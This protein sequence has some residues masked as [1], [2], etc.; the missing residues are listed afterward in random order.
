MPIAR[1]RIN[2]LTQKEY[3]LFYEEGDT[4]K[5]I[6]DQIYVNQKMRR[7]TEFDEYF[8]IRVDGYEIKREFWNYTK[9][10]HGVIVLIALVSGSGSFGAA[11]RQIIVTVAPYVGAALIPYVGAALGLV[12]GPK[13]ANKLIPPLS[14]SLAFGNFQDNSNLDVSQTFAITAQS[15]NLKK[16]GPVPRVYGRHRMFPVVAANP[17]TQIEADQLTGKMVQ[18]F[19]A[20]YDFGFGPHVI[21]DIKIG[22]TLITDFNDFQINLVD[23]NKPA[24]S[25]GVWDDELIDEFQFY[26]GDVTQEGLSIALNDNEDGGGPVANYQAVRNAASNNFGNSQ[27]IIATFIFPQGLTG[28]NTAGTKVYRTVEMRLEFAEVGT[29]D[30]HT[31]D[32]FN[33]VDDFQEP[34]NE[35]GFIYMPNDSWDDSL[36]DSIGLTQTLF[37][38]PWSNTK[39]APDVFMGYSLDIN[40]NQIRNE[41]Y[42]FEIEY[43][44]IVKDQTTRLPLE[45]L[46][47]VGSIVEIGGRNLVVTSTVTVNPTYH[48]HSFSVAEFT[49]PMFYRIKR[50]DQSGPTVSYYMPSFNTMDSLSGGSQLTAKTYD[51]GVNRYTGTQQNPLFG[52]FKFTPKTTAS[53]KIRMTRIRTYG[54][55]SFQVFDDVTW[56]SLTTRFDTAPILTTERH[57]FIELRIKATDQINGTVQN[58]SAVATS[59]LEAWDGAAWIKEPTQNPAWIYSDLITGR[60]NKKR[61]DKSKLDTDSIKAWADYCDEIPVTPPNLSFY[62]QSRF[63]CNYILDYNIVLSDAIIQ[64]TSMAQAGLTLVDGKYGVLIDRAVTTPVQIFTPRNSSRFASNR[65]YAEAPHGFK[66][67]YIDEGAEWSIRERIT[68]DDGFDSTT[69]TTFE[70]LETFGITNEEQAFRYGRFMFAQ[71][72]LRQEVISLTVD[73]EH[74]VCTRGDYVLITQDAMKVGGHPARVKA[75]SGIEITI[76]APFTVVPAT[77]YGYTYRNSSEVHTSTMT[78]TS[79]TTADLD[80][81]IPNVG[82]LIVWGEVDQITFEC[83]VKAISPNAD[84]SATIT[85]VEKD[86]AIYL[87]ESTEFIPLYSPQIST[88]QDSDLSPPDEV[89]NLTVVDNSFDCNGGAYE[90][91]IDLSWD[92]PAGTIYEVFEIYANF[93][94]GYGLHDFS[95]DPTY[96]YIVDTDNLGINHDFKILAVSATGSKIELGGVGFVSATPLSKTAPPSNVEDLFINITNET[97]QLDWPLV[98]D[99]DIDYYQIRFSPSLTATWEQTTNL[100]EVAATTSS[101]VAQARV[102][103]YHIKAFDWN[104]NESIGSALA[105]TSVPFLFN[106]NVIDETADFP[107]LP[108]TF[109]R[110]V[111]FGST[112]ILADLV[113][114]VPGVQQYQPIGEYLYSEFLDLGEIYTVRLQA[115]ITAE[116]YST[117]DLMSFWNPLS[118]VPLMSQATVG[119]WDVE[120]WYRGRDDPFS[121]S[122]WSD[123]VSIDPISEGDPD[124]WI[125]WTKFTVGDFTARIFQFK[126]VLISNLGS[127]TPRVFDAIIRSDMP[128]RSEA[129]NNIIVP[130]TGSTITYTPNFAGPGTTPNIQ[131][132]QDDASQ[133]DYYEITNKTLAGF[134]IIF[135]DK[136]DIAVQRQTDI[137]VKGYGRKAATTI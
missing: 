125:P 25:E 55:V 61:I 120:T 58:L 56:I 8:T 29:N 104:G 57:T 107:T 34:Q 99:C 91:F 110:T 10:K 113:S 121:I 129:Y 40:G 76:D 115:L 35:F 112:V 68:Y 100:L 62:S 87:A 28:I 17:Y 67:K 127:V 82:D 32:D 73:F 44:G 132:T 133:G 86:N 60:V 33:F 11:I 114:G 101:T 16:F 92:A 15:N 39:S 75:V 54:G 42:V 122:T 70:E 50:T 136:N 18:Y 117:F 26:K 22:G 66:V 65:S 130:N 69:A 4:L 46:F 124:D 48:W 83:I 128:D 43:Y 111:D 80:G 116:G 85:F 52:T 27:E 131:V 9:P 1:V 103:S 19:Y 105:I 88:V 14:P 81:S 109:D 96:R 6:L 30:W 78:I 98:A 2:P 102:G 37:Y 77:S 36:A 123:M 64:V 7:G 53:I 3:E 135:K 84:L 119:D 5:E 90:Y 23:L 94:Q 38:H 134:D 97:L 74:L 95:S 41:D 63:K 137:H 13:I 20:I 108:G 45:Q 24:V 51:V 21:E 79:S 106:L 49:Q 12:Y 93:G 72:R 89:I 47:A 31:F 71:G 59:V 126:L 118:A